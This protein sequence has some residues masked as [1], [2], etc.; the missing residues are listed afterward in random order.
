MYIM[1]CYTNF[2][3]NARFYLNNHEVIFIHSKGD[4]RSEK[5]HN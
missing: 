1:Y 3:V 4:S 5:Y 2:A